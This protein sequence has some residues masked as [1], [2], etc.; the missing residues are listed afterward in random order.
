MR[1]FILTIVSLFFLSVVLAQTAPVQFGLKAGTNFSALKTDDRLSDHRT[2]YYVGGL[3]HLHFNRHF[4]LQ[5]EVT[6]SSQGAE[7]RESKTKLH[8]INVPVLGQYMFGNGLRVQTGPQLGFIT[9]AR[10]KGG[11][12]ETINKS[13]MKDAD[14]SWSFGGSYLSPV[15]LGIDVR[16]N[17][18]L[19][20]ISKTT[21]DIKNRVW[22]AGLF[23]QF[24]K[25]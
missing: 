2:G 21:A 18:G 5:P 17:L 24:P 12:E 16:Y 4:A 10:S 6:W 7:Y 22:Q 1:K 19:T 11:A 15:G 9:T 13:W 20:D 8:Y 3:A 25:T 23:Y 14:F